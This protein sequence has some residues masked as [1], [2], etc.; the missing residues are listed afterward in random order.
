VRREIEEGSTGSADALAK[1][2]DVASIARAEVV[3]EEVWRR[4]DPNEEPDCERH[5]EERR[6]A[7]KHEDRERRAHQQPD[8][9]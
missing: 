1:E 4:E 6:N 7:Q 2:R 3:E 9:D 5:D 8:G